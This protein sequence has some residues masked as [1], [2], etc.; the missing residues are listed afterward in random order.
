MP[1]FRLPYF[2][3][4]RTRLQFA[5]VLIGIS[6]IALTGW[7]ALTGAS[8]ALREATYERLTAIRETKRRQIET[9]F[10]D[11]RSH[12]L[13]LAADESTTQALFDFE[14]G[15]SA[16]PASLPE[17]AAEAELRRFYREQAAPM[18]SRDLSESEFV[19]TWF[20]ADPRQRRLQ[21]VFLARNPHPLGAKDLLVDA[22]QL[23]AYGRAHQ[24]YHPSLH[25]YLNSFGF[26]DVFLIDARDGRVLYTVYK[27]IDIGASLR[28]GPWSQ[29]A[30]AR[31]FEEALLKEDGDAIAVTDYTPYIA[32]HF[33]P[34]AFFAAPIRRAGAV[35][36]VLAIQVAVGEVN[37]MITADRGWRE[38][39][40][41]ETGQA[42][43]VGEDRHLRSDVRIEL[44]RVDTFF[45]QLN[46]AGVDA[47]L[48]ARIRSAGTGILTLEASPD[49]ARWIADG[50]PVT[51][52]GRD[53]R[54][55]EVLRSFAPLKVQGMKW[56][57][58]AEIETAEAF[59]PVGALRLRMLALAGAIALLFFGA[60]WVLARRV[61][62]PVRSLAESARRLGRGDFST[63]LGV[64]ADDE[65]GELAASFNRMAEDLERTTVSR[66][67]LDSA[68]RQLRQQQKELED[69]AARLIRAQEDERSRIARELHDDLSQRL[70]AVA[71][72]LGKLERLG[73]GAPLV[74]ERARALRETMAQISKDVHGLSRSLHPSMVR[75]LGMRTALAQKFRSFFDRGGPPVE[76][77]IQED[78]QDVPDEIQLAVYRLVQ[79]SLQNVLHHAEASE[80]TLTLKSDGPL[81]RLRVADD[82]K[83]YDATAPGWQPGLGLASMR[84]RVHL[85]GGNF[86]IE[87]ALGKGTTITAEFPLGGTA[88]G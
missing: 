74:A 40:M 32:S 44:E 35:V 59:G 5:L 57:V 46:A 3:S 42:Y 65:I 61:T 26:Y 87:S 66:S 55:V 7:M 62:E 72:E 41:G 51:G 20:P 29:T 12:V 17:E 16:I 36:G 22:P 49:V 82:G 50:V 84:E 88:K 83:G 1:V 52:L 13:A 43:I 48:I 14:A 80:V 76:F 58:V 18:V 11:V 39:G 23:G 25:R 15:W 77:E 79:E 60:A 75:E 19:D 67:M 33:A 38:T 53:F 21:D 81:L 78:W 56:F 6:A 37:R 4:Y 68:N 45:E 8:A 69:L 28:K 27:E 2:R 24:R 34:A 64:E 73:G 71:I 30:L 10:A 31:V 63:R 70:A 86:R 47:A 54:N 9:Y 85:L